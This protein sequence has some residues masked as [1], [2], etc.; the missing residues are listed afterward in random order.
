MI[1]SSNMKISIQTEDDNIIKTA[2]YVFDIYAFVLTQLQ[3]LVV[4]LIVEVLFPIIYF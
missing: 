4:F 2:G 1:S 3:I